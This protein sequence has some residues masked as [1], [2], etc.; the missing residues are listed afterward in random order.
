[1]LKINRKYP[2]FFWL[3]L[4]VPLATEAFPAHAQDVVKKTCYGDVRFKQRVV[5]EFVV[6]EKESAS[7]VY[8]VNAVASNSVRIWA[9]R[10]AVYE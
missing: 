5:T 1:L 3:I 4:N 10:T 8:L 2:H 6:A 7:N 9:L